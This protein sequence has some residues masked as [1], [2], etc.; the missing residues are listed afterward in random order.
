MREHVLWLIGLLF[1]FSYLSLQRSR[2][3]HYAYQA[4]QRQQERRALLNAEQTLHIEI[5]RGARPAELYRYWKEHC[6][7]LLPAG[8]RPAGPPLIAAV[9]GKPGKGPRP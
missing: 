7:R 3:V 8:A 2:L 4:S 9:G 5:N 1:M 6:P